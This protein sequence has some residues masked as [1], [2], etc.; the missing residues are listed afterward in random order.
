M[1]KTTSHDVDTIINGGGM[2]GLLLANA[3]S[4][5]DLSIAIVESAKQP[6][7]WES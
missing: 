4:H 6:P 7:R 2:V 1:S 5:H 3:L